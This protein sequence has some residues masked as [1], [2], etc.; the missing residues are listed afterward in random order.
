ME[1]LL[2]ALVI[3]GTWN[4]FNFIARIYFNEISYKYAWH[5]IV[6]IWAGFLLFAQ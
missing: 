1:T 6:G 4:L 5:I 2:W 3:T